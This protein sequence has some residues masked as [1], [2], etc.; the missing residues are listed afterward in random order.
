MVTLRI[1]LDDVPADNAPLLIAP[2]SHRLGRIPASEAAAV[3]ERLGNFAC[4]ARRGDVW[5]YATSILHASARATGHRRRRVVQVDFSAV[6][7]PG[8]LEWMGI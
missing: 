3:A 6:D 5:A 7:L 8:R 1:H 2:G 4:L